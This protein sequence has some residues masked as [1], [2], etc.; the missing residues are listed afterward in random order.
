[1][2][3]EPFLSFGTQILG[4]AKPVILDI[5]G[6]AGLQPHWGKFLGLSKVVFFE[7]HPESY[8]ELKELYSHSPFVNDL[9]FLEVA[10]SRFGG[11]QKFFKTN[12][13][14]GSSL[15]EPNSDSI[16]VEETDPYFFPVSESTVAT[17]SLQSC[18]DEHSIVSVDAMK[19]DIQGAELE[20]IKG[21]DVERLSR[22]SLIEAE[23]GLVDIYKQGCLFADVKSYLEAHGFELLD[24]RNNRAPLRIPGSTD[25]YCDKYLN[26]SYHCPAVSSRIYELDT[27]FFKHPKVV[28]AM[29]DGNQIR[30]Q[31]LCYCIYN[32]FSEAFH[33]LELA[34][35]TG[36]LSQEE[37]DNIGTAVFAWHQEIRNQLVSLEQKHL[38]ADHLV[39]AQYAWVPYPC[40]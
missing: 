22:V 15:Y 38:D 17:A 20:V 24:M 29:K 7:P 35:S 10:L 8:R 4:S 11:V 19:L 31:V 14:T 18:L 3:H 30:K 5:G 25:F 6:A 40:T 32:F 9:V 16:Y 13:P 26:V 23:V 1:M 12:C 2:S 33:L 36:V 27:V 34:I 39:W 37:A 28:V 21:L